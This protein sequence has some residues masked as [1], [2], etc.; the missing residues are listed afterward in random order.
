MTNLPRSSGQA[1]VGENK[2]GHLAMSSVS[3]GYKE[4]AK[5]PGQDSNL[6]KEN[7]NPLCSFYDIPS[8]CKKLRAFL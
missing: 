7:Q 4:R 2:G 8:N 5:L 1:L 6:D 3:N